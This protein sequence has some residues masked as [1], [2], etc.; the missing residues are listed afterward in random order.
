MT[1]QSRGDRGDARRADRARRE[2]HVGGHADGGPAQESGRHAGLHGGRNWCVLK[3]PFPA[4]F[5]RLW[6]DFE[7]D[8]HCGRSHRS[9]G[10]GGGDLYR[11]ERFFI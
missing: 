10:N 8:L 2:A 3:R 11:N 1:L 9:Y 7:S 5:P 4:Q 6:A